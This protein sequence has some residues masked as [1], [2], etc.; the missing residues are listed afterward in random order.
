[1][2]GE[3]RQAAETLIRD[4]TAGLEDRFE[5]LEGCLRLISDRFE[6]STADFDT[7]KRSFSQNVDQRIAKIEQ[8]AVTKPVSKVEVNDK[9]DG[10]C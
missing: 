10:L 5:E 7:V 9:V 1:M 3:N 4:I 6:Q 8:K 2:S